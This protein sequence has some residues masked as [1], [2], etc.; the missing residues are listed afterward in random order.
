MCS[1]ESYCERCSQCR[2]S[3]GCEAGYTGAGPGRPYLRACG[4]GREG[5]SVASGPVIRRWA[6][7]ASSKVARS[8]VGKSVWSV[9]AQPAETQTPVASRRASSR[10]GRACM[11]H[12]WLR[13]GALLQ[14]P[15]DS[16]RV[17]LNR[18]LNQRKRTT[19]EPGVVVLTAPVKLVHRFG[20][21]SL[22]P[23]PPPAPVCLLLLILRSTPHVLKVPST[24]VPPL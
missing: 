16:S 22:P 8:R 23:P 9:G 5:L 14:N 15:N 19:Y 3:V 6:R 1:R 24:R 7:H 13:L 21:L 11:E 18:I 2:S 17:N 10:D 4:C 12:T 20:D